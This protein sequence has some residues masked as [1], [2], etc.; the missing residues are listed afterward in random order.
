MKRRL[1]WDSGSQ[2][3]SA[4]RKMQCYSIPDLPWFE[5]L[6]SLS[7]PAIDRQLGDLILKAVIVR[8]LAAKKYETPLIKPDRLSEK[9]DIARYLA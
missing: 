9:F 3:T 8:N 1:P 6:Q 7:A 5:A 2:P 4:R